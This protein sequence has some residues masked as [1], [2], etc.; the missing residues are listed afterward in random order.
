MRAGAIQIDGAIQ[1]AQGGAGLVPTRGQLRNLQRS[2]TVLLKELRQAQTSGILRHVLTA[3]CC[4]HPIA[5]SLMGGLLTGIS[6]N[7][8]RTRA[9][10]QHLAPILI[11]SAETA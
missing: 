10:L 1:S 7:L 11:K 5:K 2:A 9:G 8:A 3:L 4:A 6:T